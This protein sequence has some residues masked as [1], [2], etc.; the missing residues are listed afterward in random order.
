MIRS[1]SPKIT[2]LPAAD[3]CYPHSKQVL[4]L[5]ISVVVGPMWE[6][7][8]HHGDAVQKFKF[9]FVMRYYDAKDMIAYT[10]ANHFYDAS[11]T[12]IGSKGVWC[13]RKSFAP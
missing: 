12:H 3:R 10:A 7:L 13:R 4:I 8:A 9:H 6:S 1:Q 11:N 5:S 2:F